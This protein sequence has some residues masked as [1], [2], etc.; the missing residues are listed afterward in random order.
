MK[1]RNVYEVP[2]EAWREAIANAIIHRDYKFGGTSIQVRVFPDRVEVI[3]PGRLPKGVTPKNIGEMSSRRNE[4]IADMFARLDVIEKA[5]TG[6][7]RIREAMQAEGLQPPVFVD[8]G[9]FFK[10][11]LYRPK[12]VKES[13]EADEKVPRKGTQKLGS[14]AQKVLD[15]IAANPLITTAEIATEIG[16]TSDAVKKHLTN[17]TTPNH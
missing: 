2:Q 15:L 3:S 13:V 14:S 6:I 9:E 1:R 7:M 4:V 5:G 12:G 11:I 16:I 8:I 17:V 10:I